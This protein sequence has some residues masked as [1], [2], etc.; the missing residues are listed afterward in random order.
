MPLHREAANWQNRFWLKLLILGAL[1][2]VWLVT[3]LI[4]IG[5]AGL[6]L[7]RMLLIELM[8]IGNSRLTSGQPYS[9]MG[10]S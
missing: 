4:K 3:L 7:C 5:T 6:F 1:L 8:S 9:R 10:R 2:L